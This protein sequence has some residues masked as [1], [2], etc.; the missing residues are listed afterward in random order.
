MKRHARRS[1]LTVASIFSL[2][3]ST[4]WSETEHIKGVVVDARGTPVA[5]ANV[6]CNLESGQGDKLTIQCVWS[7]SADLQGR[8]DA[9]VSSLSK[10]QRYVLVAIKATITQKGKQ[11]SASKLVDSISREQQLRFKD[12]LP[13]VHGRVVDPQGKPIAGAHVSIND[14][15]VF[16]QAEAWTD[17]Y[18]IYAFPSANNDQL[19]Y[20]VCVTIPGFRGPAKG[21]S[22]SDPQAV[23]VTMPAVNS[24]RIGPLRGRLLTRDREPVAGVK[25]RCSIYNGKFLAET[26]TSEEG[27]F[28]FPEANIFEY[29][30]RLE[31]YTNERWY[32]HGIKNA[33]GT[34]ELTVP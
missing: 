21:V 24:E 28:E 7:G 14:N 34:F 16:Y 29:Q 5:Y 9:P 2:F 13:F 15:R 23:V 32:A 25:I 18:G 11:Y 31:Y 33:S 20:A 1:L 12:E 30:Y 17:A 6:V 8:F 27:I 3:C 22:S 10:D 19:F 26:T 4:S